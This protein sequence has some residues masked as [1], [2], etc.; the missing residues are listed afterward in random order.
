M[1]ARTATI[2]ATTNMTMTMATQHV[3]DDDD[4][5]D[6][7]QTNEWTTRHQTHEQAGTEQAD[8]TTTQTL[9][10]PDRPATESKQ[11]DRQ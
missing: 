9:I 10:A 5:H 3:D 2:S 8:K 4:D 6:D 11:A 7:N 1:T